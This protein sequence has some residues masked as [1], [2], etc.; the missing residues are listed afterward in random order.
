MT[1][2]TSNQLKNPLL[3]EPEQTTGSSWQKLE[4]I[5]ISFQLPIITSTDIND[6]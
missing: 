5:L 6:Q 3:S 1:T 4:L 2:K